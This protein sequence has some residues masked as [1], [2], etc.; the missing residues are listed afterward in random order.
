MNYWI[1]VD[2]RPAGPYTGEQLVNAGLRPDTLVWRKG[3][4][5][6]IESGRVPE[7]AD[8]MRARDNGTAVP[9]PQ[10]PQAPA[11]EGYAGSPAAVAEE[12]SMAGDVAET[13]ETHVSTPSY[14][15]EII[16]STTS[17][18]VTGEEREELTVDVTEEP[19]ADE[20]QAAHVAGVPDH[21]Y[22]ASHRPAGQQPDERPDT[23][24]TQDSAAVPPCPP[25]YVAWSVIVTVL[26]CT[27]V[28]VAALILS[29]MTKSAYYKGQLE[30][31]KKYSEITQ[32]LIIAAIV[33]GTAL[34]PF[35]MVFMSML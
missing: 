17:D 4:S 21:G 7:L 1:I 27:P 30:K 13:T 2:N 9:A 34:A 23:A 16:D 14:D 11:A 28:G 3:Y 5:Q 19:A 24:Q 26:C 25:A 22:A 31:S 8:M 18:P 15:E 6:W 29:S 20:N 32:W 33:C 12:E 35:Q 10:P